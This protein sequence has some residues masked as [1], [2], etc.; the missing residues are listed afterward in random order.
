[1]I[2]VLKYEGEDFKKVLSFESWAIGLINW[3]ERFSDFKVLER[4][5][6]TDEAFILLKGEATLYTDEE[7]VEMEKGVVYNIPKGVWH[8][9]VMSRDATAMVVENDNTSKENTEKKPVNQE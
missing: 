3:S 9:I 1:M 7:S 4:H 8:H 6:E 5:L 2:E